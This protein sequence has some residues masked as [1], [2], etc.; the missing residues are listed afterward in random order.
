MSHR[1]SISVV[2]DLKKLLHGLTAP[3]TLKKVFMPYRKER[4]KCYAWMG[5]GNMTIY[6][7]RKKYMS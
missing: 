2:R 6:S 7:N 1:Y 4:R 5:T 3:N